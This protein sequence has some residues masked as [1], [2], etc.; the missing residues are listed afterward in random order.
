ML[1]VTM[2]PGLR[3]ASTFFSKRALD[4][5]ILDDGFDDPVDVGETLEVVVEI[6]YGD[7]A[8]QGGSKKAAGFDFFAPSRPAAAILLRAGPSASGGT[9]SNK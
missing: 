1:V 7:Q 4:F 5:E 2:V 6:S 9:M 8:R 3:M